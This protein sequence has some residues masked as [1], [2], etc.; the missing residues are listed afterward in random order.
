[1]NNKIVMMKI[2]KHIFVTKIIKM[3]KL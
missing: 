1:M 2:M 3:N